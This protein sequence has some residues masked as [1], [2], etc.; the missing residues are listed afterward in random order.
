MLK[1]LWTGDLGQY[2]VGARITNRWDNI[3]GQVL[4]VCDYQN[5]SSFMVGKRRLMYSLEA[6]TI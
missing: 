2:C 3:L 4:M 6:G 5:S 1:S